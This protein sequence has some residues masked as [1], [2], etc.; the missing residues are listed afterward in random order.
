MIHDERI[1]SLNTEKPAR[2]GKYVIYWMQASVRAHWNHA[3]EYAI[4]T[5]NSLHKPLIVIFG[6]TDEFPNANSRHY[7]FLIEGL[8]DVEDALMKRGV[9]LVVEN[10]RPPQLSCTTQMRPLQWWWTG[11]TLTFRGNGWM[12]S[13]N[14]STYP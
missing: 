2:D 14:H 3:L 8:M 5:A 6:L 1:R 7:R 11:D 10:E 9:R 13:L 4:E 12:N